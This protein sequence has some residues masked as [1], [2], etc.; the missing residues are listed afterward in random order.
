MCMLLF[1]CTTHCN[2]AKHDRF[3]WQVFRSLLLTNAGPLETCWVC[4]AAPALRRLCPPWML[5]FDLT[6]L[7]VHW[8][9]LTRPSVG[10]F[11][12]CFE[13]DWWP[14]VKGWRLWNKPLSAGARQSH[15]GWQPV[16]VQRDNLSSGFIACKAWLYPPHTKCR[17]LKLQLF[18]GDGGGSFKMAVPSFGAFP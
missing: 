15:Q 2:N 9:F 1:H 12:G 5:R 8:L 16:T 7:L 14:T 6:S 11:F 18:G 3:G 4:C 10:C 17:S 13:V